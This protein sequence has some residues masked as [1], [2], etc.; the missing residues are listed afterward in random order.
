MKTLYKILFSLV[1]G[2]TY[3]NTTSAQVDPHFTQ[4]YVYPSWLNPALTGVFDG[5][6]RISGIY[7]KQWG[8]ISP[9]ETPGISFEYNTD[10]NAA[11]GVSMLR[12]TAGNG[13]YAYTTAY[14]NLAYSGLRFGANGNQRIV[15]GL[16]FGFIQRKFDAAKLT[17]GD[18]WNP[19]TGYNSGYI[20]PDAANAKSSTS[21]DAG[22]GALYF[23]GQPG[24]KANVFAGFAFSHITRPTDQF[25]ASGN[26][27]LPMRFTAHAGVRLAVSQ[28]FSIT[29]NAL[30]LR[31]GTAEEKMIGAYGQ[32]KVGAETDFLIGANYRFNDAISPQ[33]G[34]THKNLVL[35][36]SY[37]INTSELGK[38]IKG[39]NS[40]E[41]SLSYIFK[42]AFKPS[43][44]DFV[45]P[46]L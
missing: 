28:A 36:V 25:S 13:G 8:N 27:K 11:F 1:L 7:R 18:Q 41:V 37:D 20:S 21:F 29:P 15:L 35:G 39:S 10:K 40:F 4:Y 3:F 42:K 6:Y 22:A 9:F 45:C 17:F 5:T 46:R 14:G 19:V 32:A 31:Q 33:I 24:K 16:Q 2:I 43:E 30:Y 44:Q 38:L 26:A 23:D 34:F 12:Q